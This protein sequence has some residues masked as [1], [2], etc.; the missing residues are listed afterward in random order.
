MIGELLAASA[1]GPVRVVPLGEQDRER[2][3][4]ERVGLVGPEQLGMDP[5]WAPTNVLQELVELDPIG[6]ERDP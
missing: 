5:N 1:F 4:I 2:E 6:G 3:A